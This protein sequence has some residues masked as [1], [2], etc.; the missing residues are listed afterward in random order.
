MSKY[1]ENVKEELL[2]CCWNAKKTNEKGIEDTNILHLTE[3][4]DR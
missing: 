4:G 1:K 2:E 3:Q